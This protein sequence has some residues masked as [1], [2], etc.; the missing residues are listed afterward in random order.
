MAVGT[1][2]LAESTQFRNNKVEDGQST[3][4]KLMTEALIFTDI[5]VLIRLGA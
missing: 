1:E 3:I 4:K 5:G 2:S